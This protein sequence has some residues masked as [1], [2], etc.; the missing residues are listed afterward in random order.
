MRQSLT[1]IDRATWVFWLNCTKV[2][3]LILGKIIYYCSSLPTAL[4]LSDQIPFLSHQ[5]HQ[6]RFR[7]HGADPPQTPLKELDFRGPKGKKGK[8]RGGGREG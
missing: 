2:G 8:E 6:I 4:S 5:M 7:L 3:Q 1:A